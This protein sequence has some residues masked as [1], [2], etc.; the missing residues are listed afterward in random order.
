[1]IISLKTLKDFRILTYFKGFVNR[2][3]SKVNTRYDLT[4]NPGDAI[5]FGSV[6]ETDKLKQIWGQ[7]YANAF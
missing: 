7:Y 6:Q 1:M 2:N 3:Y 4:R 5:L